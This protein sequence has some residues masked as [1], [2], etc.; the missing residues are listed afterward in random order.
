MPTTT[1]STPADSP[2]SWLKDA[3]EYAGDFF[4]RTVL[5]TDTMRRRGNQYLDHLRQGQP[6]VLTFSYDVLLDGREMDP[7][8][9]FYLARIRDRRTPSEFRTPDAREKR[10]PLMAKTTGKAPRRPVIIID[11][12]AG[13]GPGIGGTKRDS[14]IGMALDQGYPVY[15]ILFRTWP[16]AGQTL[17]HVQ[18]AL[19]RFVEAVREGHPQSGPPAIIGNCQAGWAAA[20]LGAVRPDITGPIVMN[21][22]PLSYWAGVKGRHPM[23][24]KGGLT[25]GVWQASLWGDLGNGMFDGAH[26]VAG[27]EDLN[28]ANTLWDKQYHLW[29]NVDTEDG[30]YLDFERWWNGYYLLTTEEIHFIV[31]QL[32][33]GNHA[34]R[35]QLQMTAQPVD[36]KALAGPIVV[37]A[38]RGDNITPPQQAL[39]WIPA[40]WGSVDEIRRRN[41]TIVYMVHDTVGHLGIFVSASVSRKEHREILASIDLMDYLS[42][43]LYEMVIDDDTGDSLRHVRF[44]AR[45]M[46]DI[47][48]LDDGDDDD[49]F[50]SAAALSRFNDRLYRQW[51][52]PW[53]KAVVNDATAEALRQLH[54]LR[55]SSYGISDLNPWV[56]PVARLAGEVK[57]KRRPVSSD[58]PFLAM[59]KMF[60]DTISNS[61]NLYRDFRDQALESWFYAIFDNPW[62]RAMTTDNAA[63]ESTETAE[64]LSGWRAK[65]DAGGFAEAVVRIMVALAHAGG[66]ARRRSLAGYDRLAG[67]DPRLAELHGSLLSEMIKVQSGFMKSAP[68]A[69][70][71]A[72]TRML[73]THADR[74]HAL[75]IASSL[76]IIDEADADDPVVRM[77]DAIAAVMAVQPDGVNAQ[78]SIGSGE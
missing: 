37:F 16:V 4:Q 56:K 1:H 66:G 74:Q 29:A 49:A 75:A 10:R 64:S 55:V 73:P 60:S 11:P 6:P 36:L 23:R 28:P 14:E 52:R 44:E 30:R 50:S 72:L 77:R 59:E 38:S 76:I 70:L 25:G 46:A 21:G 57:R 8:T 18:Q 33:V 2:L 69:A 45:E 13:H 40:V 12:R 39:N 27:F 15:V 19:A 9:N 43:G 54:P 78:V 31:D 7:P 53:V 62:M 22:A 61:L 51:V 32:F 71:S 5:Y 20:L 58:N 47:L 17:D 67:E 26:L 65:I 63:D 24:Y 68:E 34:E 48:A 41:Q 42:P 35:G 3:T